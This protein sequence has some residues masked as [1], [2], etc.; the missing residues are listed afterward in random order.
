VPETDADIPAPRAIGFRWAFAGL[1]GMAALVPLG[2]LATGTAYGESA[3]DDLVLER[4]GLGAV[5]TGLAR[6]SDFW[7]HSLFPGYDFERSGHPTLAYYASAA[8]GTIL[9]GLAVI[10][11][12]AVVRL[13]RRRSA[14]A[15]QLDA[16]AAAPST[17]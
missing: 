6:Y 10:G 14:E 12:F 8:I 9:I 3:P 4:Y 13:V 7:S 15:D 16:A 11:L 1:A 5:P 17:P 2:L